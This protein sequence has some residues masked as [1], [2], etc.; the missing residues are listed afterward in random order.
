MNNIS[1]PRKKPGIT[2]VSKIV[3]PRESKFV[4]Y[5]VLY[6]PVFLLS[7]IF[8]RKEKKLCFME[9]ANSNHRY[10]IGSPVVYTIY[11]W[12]DVENT[13]LRISAY[14]MPVQNKLHKPFNLCSQFSMRKPKKNPR[15]LHVVTEYFKLF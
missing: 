10:H 3:F 12:S 13:N 1:L 2:L 9:G 15:I 4:C 8:S 6:E 14:K 5:P 11:R 7:A